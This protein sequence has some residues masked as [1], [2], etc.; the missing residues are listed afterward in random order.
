MNSQLVYIY[1]PNT[2]IKY[3]LNSKKGLRILKSYIKHYQTGGTIEDIVRIVDVGKYLGAE[4]QANILK[5]FPEMAEQI[6]NNPYKRREYLGGALF[7]VIDNLNFDEPADINQLIEPLIKIKADIKYNDKNKLV[8]NNNDLISFNNKFVIKTLVELKADINYRGSVIADNDDNVKFK[9]DPS[10]PDNLGTIS[11]TTLPLC[12]I[13]NGPRDFVD[14]DDDD[15]VNEQLSVRILEKRSKW[16]FESS[17]SSDTNE[18]TITEILL[19]A[20]ADINTYI[21]TDYNDTFNILSYLIDRDSLYDSTVLKNL[22]KHGADPNI[23]VDKKIDTIYVSPLLAA[24]DYFGDLH[25]HLVDI[26]VIGISQ[27]IVETLVEKKGDINFTYKNML[28]PM[29]N[30]LNRN[31]KD[32]LPLLGDPEDNLPSPILTLLELKADPNTRI[33]FGNN[34]INILNLLF[35]TTYYTKNSDYNNALSFMLNTLLSNNNNTTIPL[36]PNIL[37]MVNNS[38]YMPL[39]QLLMVLN[40]LY[41][42]YEV[43]DINN[44]GDLPYNIK[45]NLDE[46][47]YNDSIKYFPDLEKKYIYTPLEIAINTLGNYPH[48]GD[49]DENKDEEEVEVEQPLPPPLGEPDDDVNGDETDKDHSDVSSNRSALQVEQNDSYEK[50]DE[51]EEKK[52]E[53]KKDEEVLNGK[54]THPPPPPPPNTDMM[55]C[56]HANAKRKK[57]PANCSNY[58]HSNQNNFNMISNLLEMKA[59]PNNI[60]T[61]TRIGLQKKYNTSHTLNLIPKIHNF[62]IYFENPKYFEMNKNHHIIQT[63]ECVEKNKDNVQFHLG[64]TLSLL[65]DATTEPILANDNNS[66]AIHMLNKSYTENEIQ[67][68]ELNMSYINQMNK[69]LEYNDYDDPI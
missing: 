38:L 40:D 19:N 17:E 59:N 14:D 16:M 4:D 51:V 6:I 41:G 58:F 52:D 29:A 56:K 44:D 54:N 39:S 3:K 68:Y 31:K 8:N 5:A 2:Q 18:N 55:I 1:D 67:E 32:I 21:H 48:I 42:L 11:V 43:R 65:R 62:K 30:L 25:G 50:K 15:D 34:N 24:V 53:E 20:K 28:P 49:V 60:H 26:N 36:N 69:L 63:D 37:C 23:Q 7:Q 66:G 10:K 46:Q 64:K 45:V 22:I 27:S 9:Y 33:I 47:I 12:I 35:E 61:Y 13:R 57:I